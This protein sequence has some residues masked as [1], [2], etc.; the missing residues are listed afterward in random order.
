MSKAREPPAGTRF[1]QAVGQ[2]Q[3]LLLIIVRV[4]QLLISKDSD[5]RF[6]MKNCGLNWKLKHISM[7]VLCTYYLPVQKERHS[8]HFRFANNV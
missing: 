6:H 2:L 4:S 5:P 3:K 8:N 7:L 1:K